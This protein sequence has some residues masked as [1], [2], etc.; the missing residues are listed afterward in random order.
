MLQLEAVSGPP[1]CG[2]HTPSRSEHSRGSTQSGAR[3]S[4]AVCSC[5]EGGGADGRGKLIVVIE[6]TPIA[7]TFHLLVMIEMVLFSSS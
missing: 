5:R 6:T 4:P 7:S 3:S 2:G 1:E